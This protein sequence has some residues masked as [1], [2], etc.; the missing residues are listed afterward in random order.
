MAT[1]A[2]ESVRSA[3]RR[4]AAVKKPA[5]QAEAFVSVPVA[6]TRRRST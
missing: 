5:L 3:A 6:S 1:E 2:L 4:V